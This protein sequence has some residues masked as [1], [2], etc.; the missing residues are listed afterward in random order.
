[1]VQITDDLVDGYSEKHATGVETPKQVKPPWRLV[2]STSR[3]IILPSV[4]GAFLNSRYSN[5]SEML[6]SDRFQCRLCYG[7]GFYL[8]ASCMDPGICHPHLKRGHDLSQN[9][10][11]R[12]KTEV[13]FSKEPGAGTWHLRKSY[14]G[15]VSE[16]TSRT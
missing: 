16:I 11:R 7:G 9:T 14:D 1:M 5:R 6:P 8:C 2:M 15:G 12:D 13:A 10:K 4:P 3:T